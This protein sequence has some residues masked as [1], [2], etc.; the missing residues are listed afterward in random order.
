MVSNPARTAFLAALAQVPTIAL[1]PAVVSCRGVSQPFATGSAVG[2][3]GCQVL[4]PAFR[5]SSVNGPMPCIA[6]C[7]DALRPPWASWMP[8]AGPG[9]FMKAI[10]GLDFSYGAR[11]E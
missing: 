10:G 7:D 11:F 1:P 5:F 2:P 4:A 9:R 3:T 8:I 6:V